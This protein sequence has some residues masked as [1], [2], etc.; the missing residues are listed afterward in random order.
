MI[1]NTEEQIIINRYHN[2]ELVWNDDELKSIR[3]NIKEAL[4][5]MWTEQCCYCKRGMEDEFKMVI[6]IEHILPKSLFKILTFE[7]DN[8]NL[9]CKRCNMKIKKE[10]IDFLIDEE[11]ALDKFRDKDNYKFI[12]PN[13]DIYVDNL[14]YI[15]LVVND[16]KFIKYLSKTDK[17]KFNYEYF[18]LDM[19]ERSTLNLAQGIE[20]NLEYN[21]ENIPIEIFE[22]LIDILK[23]I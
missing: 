8:L 10:R 11:N 13:L 4:K 5:T 17:G 12:H 23:N 16:K 21:N 22:E 19:I 20:D 6:D 7:L 15:N 1:F 18:H 9:S 3:D 2:D 14:H